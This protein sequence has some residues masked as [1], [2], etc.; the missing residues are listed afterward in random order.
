MLYEALED[1]GKHG[2]RV[3]GSSGGGAADRFLERRHLSEGR[4]NR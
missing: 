2:D 3:D 1:L 4:H